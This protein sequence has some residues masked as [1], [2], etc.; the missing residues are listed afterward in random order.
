MQCIRM[1][2]HLIFVANSS[3]LQNCWIELLH[4]LATKP[5]GVEHVVTFRA[6]VSQVPLEVTRLTSL[7]ANTCITFSASICN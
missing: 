1:Y 6:G 2:M 5:D 4:A 7:S 3:S